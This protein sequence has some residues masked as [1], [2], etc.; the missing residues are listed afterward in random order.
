MTGDDFIK[1]GFWSQL[2]LLGLVDWASILAF[3]AGEGTWY[4][5]I[6]FGLVNAVLLG[7]AWFMWGWLKEKRSPIG[8]LSRP[9]RKQEDSSDD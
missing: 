9:L 5:Y 8:P 4:H 6:G 3:Q 1:L 7:A 2:V